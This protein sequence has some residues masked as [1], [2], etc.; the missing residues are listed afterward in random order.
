[1]SD[2]ASLQAVLITTTAGS[3]DAAEALAARL[4]EGRLAAC[5]QIAPITSL[6]AWDGKTA[7]A[8]EYLLTIKTRAAL[9][10]V[11]EAL[12]RGDHDYAVPEIIAVAVNDISADYLAW[13]LDATESS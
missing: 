11:I 3:L 9:F 2:G 6:Y 5:V 1:V 8:A 7:R 12:V 10:P 13:L 4:V